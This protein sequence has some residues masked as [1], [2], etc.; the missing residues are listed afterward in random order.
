VPGGSSDVTLNIPEHNAG[1]LSEDR[2]DAARDYE[3]EQ[4]HVNFGVHIDTVILAPDLR[5]CETPI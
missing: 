4:P 5:I 3:Q 2:D 1:D